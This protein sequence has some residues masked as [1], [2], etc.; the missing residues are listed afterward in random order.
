M[1]KAI[2][3]VPLNQWY[4]AA[5]DNEV[6][7][8]Q[9]GCTTRPL[10]VNLAG[11]MLVLF[12]TP[13]GI[14]ALHAFCSHQGA[15]LA[16]GE[17][18]ES[19]CVKCPYHGQTH[20][21]NG[22]SPL[23]PSCPK[24]K[25]SKLAQVDSYPVIEYAGIVWVYLGDE[26][27]QFPHLLPELAQEN[28]RA[29]RIE[30]HF[31]AF[32]RE[33]LKNFVDPAHIAHTHSDSL[34]DAHHPEVSPYDVTKSADRA[35]ANFSVSLN[36]DNPL[37]PSRNAET[38][39]YFEV[40]HFAPSVTKAVIS[41]A[42]GEFQLI[43]FAAHTP[44]GDGS[45]QTRFILLRNFGLAAEYDEKVSKRLQ[46]VVK[47]DAEMLACQ[48]ISL[49]AQPYYTQ[50]DEMPRVTALIFESLCQEANLSQ[51]VIGTLDRLPVVAAPS[52]VRKCNPVLKKCWEARTQG[53]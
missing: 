28:F 27:K 11:Q 31:D 8:H 20:D 17:V 42:N 22:L 48:E 26:P 23:S 18:L 37:F 7:A 41:N 12:R 38:Q 13:Q 51:H 39:T 14:A 21:A 4:P 45:T 32:I 35:N 34:G 1:T 6:P 16:Q 36:P 24:F 30:Q 10:A 3:R 5:W 15:A 9:K 40:D 47:E 25:L 29:V 52:P 19:G 44:L 50:A 43:I 46:Q 2:T 33:V 49:I 53:L